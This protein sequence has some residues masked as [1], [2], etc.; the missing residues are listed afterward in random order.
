VEML[1]EYFAIEVRKAL[2]A[3]G[4]T[5]LTRLDIEVEESPGQSAGFSVRFD[6]KE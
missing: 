3:A 1:A 2:L 5:H 6:G 4:H